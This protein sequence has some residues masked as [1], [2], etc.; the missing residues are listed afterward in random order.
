MVWPNNWPHFQQEIGL[1]EFLRSLPAWDTLW[2]CI[3]EVQGIKI[4]Y[5]F[6]IISVNNSVWKTDKSIFQFMLI[7]KILYLKNLNCFTPIFSKWQ[8][9]LQS[10][11]FL[12]FSQ[13]SW[14]I[15]SGHFFIALSKVFAFHSSNLKPAAFLSQ[16]AENMK[17]ALVTW[18]KQQ[19]IIFCLKS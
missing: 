16:A 6:Q 1:A 8:L 12:F 3:T 15:S 9:L 11:F 14:G 19:D 18:Q 2:S 5:E 13:W 10:I 4:I 17:E 7:P